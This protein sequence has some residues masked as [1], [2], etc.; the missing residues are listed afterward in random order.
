MRPLLLGLAL[1]AASDARAQDR[2]ALLA[3]DRAL[4][5]ATD[6]AGVVDGLLSGFADDAVYL[7]PRAPLI[8]GKTAIR[9][10]LAQTFE[11]EPATLTWAPAYAGVSADGTRGYTYGWTRLSGGTQHGKYLACWRRGPGGAWRVVAYVRTGPLGEPPPTLEVA[12]A[13]VPPT[14][15]P[16]DPRELLRADS[17]FAAASIARGARAAF[18]DYA[19]DD[20]IT[21]GGAGAINHGKAAIGRAFDDFPAG[22]VLAWAPVSADV[23]GTG[24]LGYT[25]GEAT[26]AVPA[27]DGAVQR[28]YSKYLTV[29]RREPSGAWRFV[30]DGG[31][32]RPAP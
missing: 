8:R 16:A 32:A 27:A 25:V 24:D 11:R 19:A 2:A 17:A 7:H 14:S 31:N 22:A 21:L 29:W 3:A 20:A 26:V 23:A 12:P 5:R 15:G 18:L 4:A 13:T 1:L 30:A 28:S 6:S 9:A 10:F